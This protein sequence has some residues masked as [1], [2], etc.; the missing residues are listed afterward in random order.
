MEWATL[1]RVRL[2]YI[3]LQALTELAS[4]QYKQKDW[5]ELVETAS[6]A[7]SLE[8]LHEQC[9][10][11]LMQAYIAIQQPQLASQTFE[12]LQKAFKAQLNQTPNPRLGEIYQK[13]RQT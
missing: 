3:S 5:M 1:K 8:P 6:Q 7:I 13:I 9:T 12:N 11:L 4:Y 10:Y 2:D